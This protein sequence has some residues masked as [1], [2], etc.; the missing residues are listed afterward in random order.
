LKDNEREHLITLKDY[1]EPAMYESG[2]GTPFLKRWETTAKAT[3]GW[4]DNMIQGMVGTWATP[5]ELKVMAGRSYNMEIKNG[6]ACTCKYDIGC[7]AVGDCKGGCTMTA[8]GCGITGTANC[9]GN[10]PEDRIK[11]TGGIA[12]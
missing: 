2:E 10:C 8:G 7:A 3:L 1:F 12:K 4:T 9:T 6:S 5:E 11:P